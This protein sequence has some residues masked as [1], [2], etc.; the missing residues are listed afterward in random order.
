[1]TGI[2][3]SGRQS[4]LSLIE[5]MATLAVIA[6]LLQLGL[7]AV[8]NLI[9]RQQ[10]RHE[11]E[12]LKMLLFTVRS[13]A[14]LSSTNAV[15]CPLNSSNQCHTDWNQGLTAF[16]D[17]N[18]NRIL[19]AGELILGTTSV[20]DSVTWRSYPRKA[21][22]VNGKGYAG[23][24]NGT[25]GYCRTLSSGEKMGAAFIISRMGRIRPASDKNDNG[26]PENGSGKEIRCD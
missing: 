15:L 7:P 17:P 5:L 21:F 19:D 16:S 22:A 14:I 10:A 1:M 3:S 11:I 20:S 2:Y 9:E 6:I 24:A 26:I 8:R 18:K 12:Q 23:Y 13:Q 4:G 25:L